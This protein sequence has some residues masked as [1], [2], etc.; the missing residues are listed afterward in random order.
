MPAKKTPASTATSPRPR[1]LHWWRLE[2][3]FDDLFAGRSKLSASELKRL[4]S[5]DPELS[6][7]ARESTFHT[8]FSRL[9]DVAILD[10]LYVG[11]PTMLSGEGVCEEVFRGWRIP[12]RPRNRHSR[13]DRHCRRYQRCPSL[14]RCGSLKG[15]RPSSSCC[16]AV[17]C[18]AGRHRLAFPKS[19]EV[20]ILLI[21]PIV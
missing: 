3:A 16:S 1:D 5:I 15:C 10:P 7:Q 9:L 13:R 14:R 19:T 2:D 18:A 21:E 8:A 17:R 11:D 12:S 4:L 6:V 20:T